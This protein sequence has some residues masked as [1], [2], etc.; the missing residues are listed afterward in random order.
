M[1]CNS[2]QAESF[3]YCQLELKMPSFGP[4]S[5]FERNSN[6]LHPSMTCHLFHWRK[7]YYVHIILWLMCSFFWN[8]WKMIVYRICQSHPAFR[9][10][11]QLHIYAS[12]STYVFANKKLLNLWDISSYQ[13]NTNLYLETAMHIIFLKFKALQKQTKKPL[14]KRCYFPTYVLEKIF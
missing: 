5:F 13:R 7:L 14:L 9:Y 10:L 12:E 1:V 11:E 3:C 2:F 8:E 6:S 4:W